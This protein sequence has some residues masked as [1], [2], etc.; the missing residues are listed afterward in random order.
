MEANVLSFGGNSNFYPAGATTADQGAFGRKF[1]LYHALFEGARDDLPG[2][3][4]WARLAFNSPA[5][6]TSTFNPLPVVGMRLESRKNPA[7]PLK[8]YGFSSNHAY[9]RSAN[10]PGNFNANGN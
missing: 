1:K 6:A 5:G 7:Q 8:S 10:N 3:G 2:Y 4:G 9:E